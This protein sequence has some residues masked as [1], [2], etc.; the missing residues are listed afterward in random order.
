MLFTGEEISIDLEND[1][2]IHEVNEPTFMTDRKRE[3]LRINKDG[4]YYLHT[5]NDRE[6]ELIHT[7]SF[8]IKE[9]AKE[10]GVEL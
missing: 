10:N 9:W 6:N 3:T 8:I 5:N 4:Y 7:E 2:I 1:K